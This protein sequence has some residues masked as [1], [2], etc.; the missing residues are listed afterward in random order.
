MLSY[1]TTDNKGI[2]NVIGGTILWKLWHKHTLKH[3]AATLSHAEY[4]PLTQK[5]VHNI[6]S[7]KK[8]VLK[9]NTQ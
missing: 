2:L 3:Y 7:K 9:S 5:D 6:L 8:K 1:N 4:C